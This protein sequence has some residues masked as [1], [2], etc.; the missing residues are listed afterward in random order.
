MTTS[1]YNVLHS[2]AC[3]AAVA[4]SLNESGY[5]VDTFGW[6]EIR[7]GHYY[8]WD[9]DSRSYI[10]RDD[11]LKIVHEDEYKLDFHYRMQVTPA[12]IATLKML[13]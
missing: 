8:R 1:V 7:N 4:R 9:D 13:R 3:N 12:V 2:G 5:H 6:D 10:I 11:L